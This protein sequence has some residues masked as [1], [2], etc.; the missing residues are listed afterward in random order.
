MFKSSLAKQWKTYD[1]DDRYSTA[2]LRFNCT[3]IETSIKKTEVVFEPTETGKECTID[4]MSD[5]LRSLFYISLVDS[6]LDIESQMQR[7]I[8]RNLEH[9]SFNRKPPILTIVA[10]EEPE[11]HIAPHLLGKL[12]ENLKKIAGKSN[13]QVIMTS[14]SR[15]LLSGLNQRISDTSELTRASRHQRFERLP[16]QRKKVHRISINIS[17]KQSRLIPNCTL[18]NL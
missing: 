12:V 15:Q 7:E 11:N 8:E 17:K 6:I 3:D 13:A 9:P 10:L 14:H 4:K 18:Q 5:G 16:Y 1:S 2:S